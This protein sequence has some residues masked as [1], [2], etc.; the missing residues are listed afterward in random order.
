[1]KV[2]DTVCV[3]DALDNRLVREIVALEDGYVYVSRREEID[4]AKAEKREPN[5]IGFEMSLVNP[6]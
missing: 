1:M 4:R 2:G 5:C 6:A 3:L